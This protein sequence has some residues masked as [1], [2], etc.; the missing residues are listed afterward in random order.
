MF[1]IIALI[2]FA[3]FYFYDK[4]KPNTAESID[5]GFELDTLFIKI[6]TETNKTAISNIKIRGL[7]S[8]VT[9]CEIS[10]SEI[11]GLVNLSEN[12]ITLAGN[13]EY[14]LKVSLNTN[15]A[16]GIY[17]GEL[18]LSSSCK[19]QKIPVILEVQSKIVVFDA[20]VN[21]YPVGED[22][23]Q[24]DRLDTS[25]KIYDLASMGKH[26]IKVIYFIKSLDGLINISESEDLIIDGK[27]DYIK[28]LD[29]SKSLN[30]GDYVFST[31]V[32][33]TDLAGIKSIGISST[34]FN[35][36]KEKSSLVQYDVSE[37]IITL[38]VIIFGFFFLIFLGLFI[39]SLVFRDKMLKEMELMYNRELRRQIKLIEC[40]K[41]QAYTKI[42][43]PKEREEYKREVEEIK[44]LR[45]KALRVVQ[46]KK[47]SEFKKIKK[48][49]RG[50]KLKAR[51][52]KWKKQGYDTKVLEKKYKLPG[53]DEFRKKI[54]KWKKQGYDTS[55]LEK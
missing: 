11:G 1:F 22:L 48:R 43:N 15:K 9:P 44:R 17:V 24:G 38:I 4:Y 8:S 7:E 29:I 16:P 5:S 6:S 20:N 50:N 10:F 25:I 52:T 39:Y 26:N 41:Q 35:I 46:N 2:A 13:D 33:Y 12:K 31:V 53:I 49:F 40:Q 32:E 45:L 21:I 23:I 19:T 28:G 51:L 54:N 34:S 47:I 14:N 27:L 30:A 55:I 3:G 36:V 18:T 42:N 37:S